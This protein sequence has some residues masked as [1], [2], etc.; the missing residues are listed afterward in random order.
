MWHMFASHFV[1]PVT[2]NSIFV[3]YQQVFKLALSCEVWL[4]LKLT[5]RFDTLS[6]LP[7]LSAPPTALTPPGCTH[8]ATVTSLTFQKGS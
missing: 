7:P 3:Y 6:P 2:N 1:Y 8:P 4:V 5:V